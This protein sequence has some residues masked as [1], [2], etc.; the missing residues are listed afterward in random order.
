MYILYAGYVSIYALR[1][2][3]RDGINP[4]IRTMFLSKQ[5]VYVLS[6]SVMWLGFM[7]HAYFSVYALLVKEHSDEVD[8]WINNLKKIAMFQSIMIGFVIS[9]VRISEP[10][11]KFLIKKEVCEW[12]GILVQEDKAPEEI[13][14]DEEDNIIEK[15]SLAALL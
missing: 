14:K 8:R 2:L 13:L 7:V 11:F 10:Y 5:F 12:F 1:R 4:K 3:W 6:Y 15:D 9:L